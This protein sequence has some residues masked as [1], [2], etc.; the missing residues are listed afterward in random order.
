MNSPLP[1]DPNELFEQDERKWE[2]SIV[3]VL[4]TK[5]HLRSE[6]REEIKDWARSH[7]RTSHLLTF[8]G[9]G[10]AVPEFPLVLHGQL[11]RGLVEKASVARIFRDFPSTAMLQ[12]YANAMDETGQD[13][14]LG[15]VFRWPQLGR[16]GQPPTAMVLHDRRPNWDVPGTRL[17]WYQPTA[18]LNKRVAGV[19]RQLFMYDLMLLLDE[20]LLD[21]FAA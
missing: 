9:F 11:I 4:C 21:G 16:R 18:K 8:T 2:H 5:L 15:V 20:I 13:Q 7:G 10:M 14:N 6:V 3:Q 1:V 12:T 19:P 17:A